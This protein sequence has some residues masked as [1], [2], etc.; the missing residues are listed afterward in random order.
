MTPRASDEDLMRAVAEG[1]ER[2]F[3]RL[4]RRHLPVVRRIA[5][6]MLGDAAADDV[7]QEVFLRLWRRPDMFDPARGRFSTWLHRVAANASIDAVRRRREEQ[8]GEGE[9]ERLVDHAPT[10]E[11]ALL[12]QERAARVRAAISR[13]PERQRLALTLSHDAGHGNAEIAAVMDTS[14][15]AVESLLARARRRLKEMLRAELEQEP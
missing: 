12:A 13:L 3:A 11:R 15:E 4:V 6:R 1:D 7:A 9:A 2:A 14:V 5:W 10:P 8:L